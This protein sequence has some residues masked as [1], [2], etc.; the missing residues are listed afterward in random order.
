MSEKPEEKRMPL[1]ERYG[2]HQH[3]KA[4]EDHN[5]PPIIQ[6]WVDDGNCIG[7]PFAKVSCIL[8][9]AESGKL[10]I[11]VEKVGTFVIEGPKVLAFFEQFSNHQAN[12]LKSDKAD[13]TSVAFIVEETKGSSS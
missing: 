12:V 13:I 4:W 6:M 11:S 5:A 9:A 3:S 8:Y 10:T 1:S 7:F 2:P